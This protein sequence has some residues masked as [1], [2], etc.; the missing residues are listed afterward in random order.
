MTSVS[1]DHKPERIDR[2]RLVLGLL[3]MPLFFA[4]FMFLPAGSWAWPKGWLFIL[5]FL[6]LSLA[7]WLTIRRVNPD[8]LPARINA[9]EGTKPWDKVLVGFI[10]L[11]MLAV[12]PVAALDDGRFQWY[13]LPW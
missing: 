1:A 8:L 3:G 12:V 7:A 6:V 11:A 2:R 9:H 10:L 13:P 4:L 5:V